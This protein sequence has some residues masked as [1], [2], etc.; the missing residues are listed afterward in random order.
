MIFS[1]AWPV[2]RKEFMHMARDRGALMFAL[3]VPI[4]QLVFFGFAIDTN[5]RGIPTA[6]Y[7]Q[8]RTQQ[9]RRM[10]EKF[11]NSDTFRIAHVVDSDEEMYRLMRGGEVKTAIKVPFDYSRRLAQGQTASVQVLVDGSDSSI[12]SYAVNVSNGLVLQEA[13]RRAGLTDQLPVE[14]RPSVL[15]NPGMRSPNFFVP[16]MIAVVLQMM[17]ITLTAL[18]VVRERER[19]TLEQLS[20]TPVTSLGLMTGKMLPYGVLGFAELCAILLIMRLVFDVPIHGSPVLL[21]MLSVP[22]LVTSLGLGLLISTKAKSQAEAFQ[23]SVGTLLPS[24]FLSGYIFL[25]ENMPE[26]FQVISHLVPAT[27]YIRILRG[28][29][30]RGADLSQL[31]MDGLIL[32]IMGCAAVA[33]AA[34]QFVR[35]KA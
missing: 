16:G 22:F 5:I 24:V 13:L 19:G 20:L 10:I 34:L 12:S 28:V 33:L 21:L 14:V 4:I 35:R 6:V 15:F 11:V 8:E 18:S 30:L 9:S 31:W 7:D 27:Y 29:I 17:L 2:C 23:M 1:G 25:I 32:S 3:G 26:V